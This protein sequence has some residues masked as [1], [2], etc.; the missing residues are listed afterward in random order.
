MVRYRLWQLWRALTG[1]VQPDEHAFVRALLT[2][3]EQRLFVRLPRYDQRHALDLVTVLRRHSPAVADDVYVLALLHDIGK[4]HDDG[5]PLGLL[6]YGIAVLSRR[7]PRL[8]QWMATWL[9][10]M[11][12]HAHHE[13]RSATI[14]QQAG[15]RP[16]VCALLRA[17]ADGDDSPEIR[18]FQWADDQC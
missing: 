3:D 16:T 18:L 11:R 9:E 2:V 17:V 14:A 5:R 12:R 4:A 15:V 13:R 1:V 8:Y 10:P 7:V 6:W